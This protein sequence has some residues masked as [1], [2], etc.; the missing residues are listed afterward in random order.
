[1]SV[2]RIWQLTRRWAWLFA[3]A[4]ILAAGTSYFVSSGLPKVYEGTAKL[5]VAPSQAG[6]PQSYNDVLTA[7]RLT[8]TYSEV[9]KT[10]PIV[11]AGAVEAGLGLSYERA[12]ALLDVRPVANTQLIQISAR[13]SD[14]E[15]AARFANSVTNAFVQYIHARQLDR[16]AASKDNLTRQVGQLS[17]DIA[18]RSARIDALRA[19][20]PSATRD[21]ELARLQ[22][23]LSQL[24]QSNAAAARS[25]EDERL[26][27]ARSTDLLAVVEPATPAP[28][29]VAPRVLLN[30]ALAALLAV[31]VAFAVAFVVEHLDDRLSSPERVARFTGL[32]ALGSVPTLPKDA[33]R[34]FDLLPVTKPSPGGSASYDYASAGIGEMFRLLRANLQFAAVERP[35]RSV[36]VTSPEQGDGKT[37]VTANLAVV[38]AQAGQ[39]VLLVEADLRRPSL[40]EVFGIPNRV[41]LTSLL[42]DEK[43]DPASAAVETRV[44]G[45]RLLPSG[46]L[47][48]NPS[49]LL[50]SQRMRTRAAQLRELADIV[51]VD[52]PPVL[53]V[54]DPA[55]LAG[56]VDGTVLVVSSVKTRGQHAA[57]TV[58]MLQKAGALVLGV[59]LNRTRSSHGSYVA[60]KARGYEAQP[61]SAPTT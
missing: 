23:E 38:L 22:G 27:E 26:N 11:E 60:Y 13:A 40:S 34:V 10:R 29:P 1:L 49:E 59:V 51:I 31:I 45:L 3:L 50:A 20:L 55:V 15:L 8:R 43:L 56:L 14:P 39:Q 28:D 42:L 46:P 54:S 37:T 19:D 52:S 25:L 48:P 24:Q 5:L 41:G 4:V 47:P 21:S 44:P 12:L 36:L 18:E 53:A 2:Q 30:V 7:E 32:H 17:T 9:L 61:S 58:S 57:Q 35:L 16:F 33:P 6:S